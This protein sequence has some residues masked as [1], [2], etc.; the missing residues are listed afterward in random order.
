MREQASQVAD[1]AEASAADRVSKAERRAAERVAAVQEEVAARRTALESVLLER[2][3][4][5]EAR[6]AVLATRRAALELEVLPQMRPKPVVF[7]K[8]PCKVK[9]SW[10]KVELAWLF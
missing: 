8:E 7:S 9:T 6:L 2:E 5:L 10:Y 1:A 3:C 4:E